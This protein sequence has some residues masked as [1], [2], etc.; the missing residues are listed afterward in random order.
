MEATVRSKETRERA[1]K[2][3]ATHVGA[4]KRMGNY[5]LMHE[6]TAQQQQRQ[7]LG[8]IPFCPFYSFVLR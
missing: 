6:G 8:S 1:K 7:Q 4:L 3:E 2:Q 5:A